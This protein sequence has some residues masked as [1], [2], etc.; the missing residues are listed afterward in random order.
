MKKWLP[1]CLLLLIT[2]PS[3]LQAQ[4]RLGILG[5]IHSSNVI[6]TNHLPGWDTATKPFEKP[7][8]GFQIGAIIEVPIGHTGLYFQPAITYI[9]KGRTYNRTNDSLISLQTDTVYNKQDLKLSYIEIPLNLT[10]KIPFTRNRLNHLFVSAGPYFSF[11]HTGT[12]TSESLTETTRAYASNDEPVSVGKGS[13]TY[14]TLD[15]GVNA[16]AGIEVGSVM[17]S[18][19][20]S[21]SLSSF[22]TA[23]YTGAFHHQ[24]AGLS[25]GIWLTSSGP[26]A[27]I[28]KRD[29]DK[30][31]INDEE[32]QCPLQPGS[33]KY[34]GC[35][36][37]DTDHDGVDDEHDS[38]PTI[39]GLARYNGCP[40]PDTDNDGIDD[41]HD[42]CPTVPGLARYNGCPI[43]DRDGD[44]LNDEIDQCPDSA[45][46][47]SNHGCP[48]PAPPAPEIKKAAEQ[49]NY[50]AH[51]VLFQ[52]G[53]DKLTDG[54]FQ[55]LDQLAVLLLSHPNWH[56][57]IE[58]YTDNSGNP[59][60]NL[61]LS[62]DRSN[63]VASYLIGK[64][65]DRQHVTAIGYGQEH[66]I[67]DNRT[68]KGKAA[69]RRVEL[70]LSV[71]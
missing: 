60:K 54:S 68:A 4:V 22:Y 58:G 42:S 49:I 48:L 55:A 66:P 3:F 7:R 31:G 34:H 13:D 1:F 46:P 8:T 40:V 59:Q 57:T 32:D 19:Y 21:R 24:V 70:K 44:G 27:P 14:K 37:P 28:R 69:N 30:D 45:G 12:V 51:N 5:G 53:K 36:V 18:G 47:V 56:L 50:I 6:E 41:E 26:A 10:Y 35:P 15:I 62:I 38:C 67:A 39:P 52:P 61:A 64:G 33:A 63:A 9:T 11:F 65:V 71:R 29:T 17:L 23:P 2:T 20:Y 43:P 16:R 25:L